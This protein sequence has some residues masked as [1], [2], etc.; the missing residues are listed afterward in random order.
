MLSNRLDMDGFVAI[1]GV[2]VL[3]QWCA[4]VQEHE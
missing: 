3:Q 4:F 2:S 1:A